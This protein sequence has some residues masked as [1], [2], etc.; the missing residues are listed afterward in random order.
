MTHVAID[1]TLET[2]T[3]ILQEADD[4]SGC[5]QDA[6]M[7]AGGD[8]CGHEGH[9]MVKVMIDAWCCYGPRQSRGDLPGEESGG[10]S[11]RNPHCHS[12]QICDTCNMY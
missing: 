5:G 12:S 3:W 10:E 2:L 6:V 1:T 11:D 9:V 7:I 4:R 8:G